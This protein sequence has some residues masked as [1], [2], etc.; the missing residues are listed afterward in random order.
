MVTV[1]GGTLVIE[2]PAFAE[3]VSFTGTRGALA[4]A[5]S[6]TYTGT[7]AGFSITRGTRL[8]LQDIGFVGA[9]EATFSGDAT[10]GVLTI[11]DGPHTARIN[12]TGD[13][14]G[15]RFVASDDGRGGTRWSRASASPRWRRRTR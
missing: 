15:A 1:A 3:N 4:L 7:V 14:L 12:L 13:Y 2:D 10:G 6:Q 5:R 8:D 11:T 9:G